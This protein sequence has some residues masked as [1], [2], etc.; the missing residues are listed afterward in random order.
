MNKTKT[1][2][3]LHLLAIIVAAGVAIMTEEKVFAQPVNPITTNAQVVDYSDQPDSQ[4]SDQTSVDNHNDGETN[5]DHNSA[6]E[7]HNGDGDGE[8]PDQTESG[9]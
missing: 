1:I 5:D 4:Q 9:K 8:Q 6:N 2:I 3:A 7:G